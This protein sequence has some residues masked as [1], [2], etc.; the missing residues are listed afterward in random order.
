MHTQ[1]LSGQ[2]EMGTA[3][4][5]Q[6]R[7]EESRDLGLSNLAEQE[8]SLKHVHKV[9]LAFVHTVPSAIASPSYPPT[10]PAPSIQYDEF[11]FKLRA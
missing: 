5:K 8:L 9:S 3:A 6:P 1:S 11:L 7:L 10:H 2:P 4:I